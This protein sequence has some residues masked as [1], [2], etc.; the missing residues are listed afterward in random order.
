MGIVRS[1]FTALLQKTSPKIEVLSDSDVVY[2]CMRDPCD[3]LH[4]PSSSFIL[5]DGTLLGTPSISSST[6][7]GLP[8]KAFTWKMSMW[9]R[10]TGVR[11]T[12]MPFCVYTRI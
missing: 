6:P 11:Y 8:A 7:H 4:I 9:R 2:A 3:L 10:S 5:K 12:S 1:I